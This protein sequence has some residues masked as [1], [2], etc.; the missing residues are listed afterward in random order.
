[1]FDIMPWRKNK[2]SVFS[3]TDNSIDLFRKQADEL[4]DSFFDLPDWGEKSQ[5]KI[6]IVEKKKTIEV[7]AEVPGVSADDLDIALNGRLLSI[8]GTKKQ[9]SESSSDNYYHM[10]RSFGSFTRTIQLPAEV[11]ESDV[12]ASYKKGVLNIELKKVKPEKSK[13]IDIKTK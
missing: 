12:D 13:R 4:L 11:D 6:D 2:P 8:S 9:E 1:M 10:E 3:R 5:P 7:K